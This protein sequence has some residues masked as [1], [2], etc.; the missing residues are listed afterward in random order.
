M[1]RLSEVIDS[2][3]STTAAALAI[4]RSEG[5]LRKWRRG[6][7]EPSASDI[8]CLCEASGFSAEW[9][10]FGTDLRGRCEREN[11]TLAGGARLKSK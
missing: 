2:F 9:L 11:R 1:E 7:S 3:G 4:G 6:Q 5:A 8:R 10:L